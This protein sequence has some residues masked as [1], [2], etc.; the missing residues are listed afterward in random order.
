MCK[1]AAKWVPHN[2]N[3]VQL[4]THYETCLISLE[5]FQ[6]EGDN[7]LNQIIEVN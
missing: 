4:C 1:I 6:H 2:L 3:E 5:C 7:M